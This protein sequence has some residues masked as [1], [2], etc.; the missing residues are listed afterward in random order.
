MKIY[1]ETT[2]HDGKTYPITTAHDTLE[3]AITYADLHGVKLICEIGG[4]WNEFEKCPICEEWYPSEQIEN[5]GLCTRCHW[6][7]ISHGF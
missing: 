3:E 5:S 4:S 7:G 2:F 1:Y 6:N